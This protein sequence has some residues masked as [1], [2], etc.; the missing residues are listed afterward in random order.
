[1]KQLINAAVYCT[2]VET[3]YL[4]ALKAANVYI[5]TQLKSIQR[6]YVS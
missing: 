6:L 1:M 4:A 2:N 3:E 5:P